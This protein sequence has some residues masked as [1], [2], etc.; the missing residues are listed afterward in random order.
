MALAFAEPM[1]FPPV[2]PYGLEIVRE[3]LRRRGLSANVVL[4]YLTREP[5]LALEQALAARTPRVVGLSFR[6]LDEAGFH[7]G[8]DGEATFIGE[9]AALVRVAKEQGAIVCLGGSGYAIAP[10]ELLRETSADVGFVGS[11][12]HDFAE[13][14]S[15]LI[16]GGQSLKEATPS[17]RRLPCPDCRRR[18]R[19]A[20]RSALRSNSTHRIA[21]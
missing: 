12:E 8:S 9:L 13:F 14:C 18:S 15:R 16:Q 11:S 5:R 21:S 10:T 6:N 3:S 2:F 7:F 1:L 4:P 17:W 19:N 20:S